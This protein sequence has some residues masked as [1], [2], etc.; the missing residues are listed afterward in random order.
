MKIIFYK[1]DRRKKENKKNACLYDNNTFFDKYLTKKDRVVFFQQVNDFFKIHIDLEKNWRKKNITLIAESY[2]EQLLINRYNRFGLKSD[3][4]LI[5]YIIECKIEK[6]I[7]EY[8]KSFNLTHKSPYSDSYYNTNEKD[9]H[10]T[11]EFSLRLS[12][13]WNF[14]DQFGVIHCK[15]KNINR[16]INNTWILCMYCNGYYEILEVL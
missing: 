3:E 7:N 13:H 14:T 12:N 10:Y 9:W 6:K 16:Y 4:E 2:S 8:K 11:P 1:L 5:E 15:I